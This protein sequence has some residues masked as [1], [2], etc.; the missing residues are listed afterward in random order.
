[1]PAKGTSWCDIVGA[2]EM[3]VFHHKGLDSYSTW[4]YRDKPKVF[5]KLQN[6]S[7]RAYKITDI[8]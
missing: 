7:F 6:I 3:P 5:K 1:M 8:E 4:S 2:F